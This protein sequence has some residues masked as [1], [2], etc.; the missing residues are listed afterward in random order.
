VCEQ[1]TAYIGL[2]S[3]LGQ[4]EE[5]LRAALV[6]LEHVDG[7]EV[8]A[9]SSLWETAPVGGPPQGDYLNAAAQ[10]RTCLAPE[11]LLRALQGIEARFGR[12]RGAR[13]GPRTLDLDL[14]LYADA[15]VST[16]DLQV[17]HPRMHE[18]LFVLGPLCEIA[19]EARHPVL[20]RSAAELLT[21]L[22]SAKESP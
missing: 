7:V 16:P 21:R 14:L 3:N 8:T 6:E 10:V 9:V 22:R 12:E 2:G 13:W 18:R 15:V 19:P 4:R 11:E 20:G 17:P 5:T 1:V